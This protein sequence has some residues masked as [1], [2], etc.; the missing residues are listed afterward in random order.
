MLGK[1]MS[2]V[3]IQFGSQE[4]AS[5]NKNCMSCYEKEWC[6]FLGKVKGLYLAG[7]PHT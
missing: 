5:Q 7:E 3:M 2:G 1:H 4:W 6:D